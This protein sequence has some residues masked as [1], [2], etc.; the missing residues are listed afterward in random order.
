MRKKMI[1]T[2]AFCVLIVLFLAGGAYFGLAKYYAGG[3]SYGTWI[4]GIYCT[5]KSVEEVNEELLAQFSTTNIEIAF[6]DGTTETI[7]MKDISYVVDY[8]EQLKAYKEKQNPYL[9]IVNLWKGKKHETELLPDI[10]FDTQK[11]FDAIDELT[12]VI[13]AEQKQN[14]RVEIIKTKN[15]YELVNEKLHVLNKKKLQEEIKQSL[16]N[17][18]YCVRIGDEC[19]TDMPLTTKEKTTILLWN[20]VN[21]FQS[22]KIRYDMGDRIIPIDA[23]VV[24][25]WIALDEE[26][27]FLLDEQGNL[28]TDEEKI[29]EFIEKLAE[30]YD[31]VGSERQ[32]QA[33]RGETVTVA[34]G[35]YGNKLNKKAEIA[36]L[37]KAFRDKADEV[38]VPEYTKKAYVR[39]KEDIGDTYIEIDMTEQMMYYYVDGEIYVETP[40][41]TGNTGR[42]MG[43]PEGVCFV[44]GKQKNRVLRGANYASF[45]NF[46]VPVRGSIGIH[47]APWRSEYGGEIYKT[48]GSHG[49]VNTPFDEMKKIYE[50]VEIGT[51]VIMFY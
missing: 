41:V 31:T 16:E 14:K 51:P 48:N 30:E 46:W 6:E 19:Y 40:V 42:R 5:G 1:L 36:Y 21:E 34:G 33:T 23:S 32:F 37:T 38:H 27:N 7:A 43:T 28:V 12:P 8:R 9:W 49:C 2:V 47:D 3:F 29:K 18:A 44:Y 4:N 45:V 15:G 24:C 11:L 26:G 13:K 20:K 25:E 17:G 50:H 39:G 22:C 10:S 35:T